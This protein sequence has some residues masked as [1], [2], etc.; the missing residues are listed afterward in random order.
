MY[1]FVQVISI[2]YILG[3][4]INTHVHPTEGYSMWLSGEPSSTS[5]QCLIMWEYY[6]FIWNDS[7]CTN[8]EHTICQTSLG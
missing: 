6:D 4:L 2:V 3:D 1:H 5:E 7:S 8:Q